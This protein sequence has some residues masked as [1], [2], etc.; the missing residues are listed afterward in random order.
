MINRKYLWIYVVITF[1]VL[2]FFVYSL[3]TFSSRGSTINSSKLSNEQIYEL[4]ECKR[5]EADLR[6]TDIFCD[7]PDFYKKQ[8]FSENDVY[9]F[10]RC[11][12]ALKNPDYPAYDNRYNQLTEKENNIETCINKSLREKQIVLLK[13]RVVHAER[14]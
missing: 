4:F 1:M 6:S 10:L 8:N 11:D 9:R 7:F 5:M 13:K 2:C 14:Q 12:F 3:V